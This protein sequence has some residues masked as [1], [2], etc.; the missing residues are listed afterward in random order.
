MC[1]VGASAVVLCSRPD[2]PRRRLSI[3]RQ[4]A[5]NCVASTSG[6]GLSARRQTRDAL[7]CKL[8]CKLYRPVWALGLGC[9]R[10]ALVGRASAAACTCL[11]SVASCPRRRVGR[12]AARPVCPFVWLPS[13]GWPSRAHPEAPVRAMLHELAI[14]SKVVCT[15]QRGMFCLR[16]RD[17]CDLADESRRDQRCIVARRPRPEGRERGGFQ[18]SCSLAL[19]CIRAY[20]AAPAVH[21]T[22]S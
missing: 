9:A 2:R 19:L 17:A 7:I 18:S 21:T 12:R 14:R 1:P 6:S 8:Y 13:G 15:T 3:Q 20:R 22:A 11:V 4:P 10:H 16:Q 5:P